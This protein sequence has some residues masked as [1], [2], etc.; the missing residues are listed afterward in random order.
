MRYCPKFII[1]NIHRNL[2]S[3]THWEASL[4]S[5]TVKYLGGL[6]LVKWFEKWNNKYE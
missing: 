4:W 6:F 3:V 5:L 2:Y 1:R